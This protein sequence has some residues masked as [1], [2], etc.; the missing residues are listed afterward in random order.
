MLYDENRILLHVS[1]IQNK[2][3][4]FDWLQNVVYMT[5]VGFSVNPTNEYWTTYDDNVL[6]VA[7]NVN[8]PFQVH[9]VRLERL[10]IPNSSRESQETKQTMGVFQ[11]QYP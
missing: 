3:L 6:N 7:H 4:F 2:I 11:L 1:S 9:W 5:H 10:R 8:P